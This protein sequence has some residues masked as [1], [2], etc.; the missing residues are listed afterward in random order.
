MCSGSFSRSAW[1]TLGHRR[2]AETGLLPK[3]GTLAVSR[4]SI[5]DSSILRSR[6]RARGGGAGGRAGLGGPEEAPAAAGPCRGSGRTGTG[7]P[8]AAAGLGRTGQLRPGEGAGAAA[9]E[10]RSS[11][12]GGSREPLRQRRS[13]Q[14]AASS[15]SSVGRGSGVGTALQ[16]G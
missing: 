12:G 5:P 3:L 16:G 11:G 7:F 2:A 4:G 8:A 13:S 10:P 14:P 9:G 1:E 6:A 15:V